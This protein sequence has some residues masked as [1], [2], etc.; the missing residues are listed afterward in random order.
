MVM[1]TETNMAEAT[2]P[3][4]ISHY[5]ETSMLHPAPHQSPKLKPKPKSKP[6]TAPYSAEAFASASCTPGENRYRSCPVKATRS[7][8][9][10]R[11]LL[12]IM[13]RL[14][15]LP[16]NS[17]RRSC[18]FCRT[19]HVIVHSSSCGTLEATVDGSEAKAVAYL[20]ICGAVEGECSGRMSRVMMR[21]GLGGEC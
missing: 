3:S 18:S 9:M 12:T 2:Q 13:L 8:T 4:G 21:C 11:S 5:N 7:A 10:A 6:H 17:P 16:V 19:Q 1:H 20:R 15:S 14:S